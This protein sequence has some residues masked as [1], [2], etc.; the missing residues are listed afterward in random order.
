MT[1]ALSRLCHPLRSPSVHRMALVDL[2][3]KI[4]C[5]SQQARPLTLCGAAEK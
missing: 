1:A 2:A 4:A 5:A 3:L